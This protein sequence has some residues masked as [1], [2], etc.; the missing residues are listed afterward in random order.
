MPYEA[1]MATERMPAAKPEEDFDF[2]SLDG[3]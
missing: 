1:G 2:F 3:D